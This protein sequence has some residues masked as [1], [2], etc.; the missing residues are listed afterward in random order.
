VAICP[1]GDQID[2]LLVSFD[3]ELSDDI[4]IFV[5]IYFYTSHGR[6]ALGLVESCNQVSVNTKTLKLKGLG[7]Q[8]FTN[9]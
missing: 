8:E 6:N 9:L 5:F 1:G 3:I 4:T 7:L 2:Q